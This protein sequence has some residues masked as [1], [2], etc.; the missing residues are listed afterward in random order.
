MRAVQAAKGAGSLVRGNSRLSSW[1]SST[2]IAAPALPFWWQARRSLG[3]SSGSNDGS[4]NTME[5][6]YGEMDESG[7]TFHMPSYTTE[8]GEKIKDVQL[9]YRTWG[10]LNEARDNVLVVCHALTGNAA[11][12]DW[13]GSFLGDG[14]PFDTSKYYVICSNLLGS[15]YGST[16][17]SSTNADNHTRWGPEF[18]RITVRD[19]VNLQKQMVRWGEGVKQVK[20]VI[21]GSLGG[22]QTLEWLFHDHPHCNNEELLAHTKDDQ[23]FVRSAMPMACGT[24][25]HTWQI[26][27]SE[28]Q[29]QCIYADPDFQEGWYYDTGKMPRSGI[30]LARMQA[31]VSYRSHA[32]YETKFGRRRMDM[33][34][35]EEIDDEFETGGPKTPTF[36]ENP[37]TVE[38]YLRY[39]GKKFYDR[40]DANSYVTLTQMM[41]TH[42]IG[43]GRG[44][45]ARAAASCKQPLHVIGIDS[46]VLYPILE[47]EDLA[48]VF[49]NANLSIVR[50]DDGHDGFLLAQDSVGPI[51]Q[52]FLEK[53]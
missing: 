25:H 44:G 47:Q 33:E 22:M 42:D 50:S 37:F 4:S 29:R 17:P 35:G 46:D 36:Y 23:P 18:P 2:S 5:D 9:R 12:N 8:S 34:N 24:H 16:G 48:A 26:A 31:M 51:I 38:S 19:A 53:I 1:M 52:E 15:C 27:V 40:F 3:S 30:G 49:P 14:L 45:V 7:K 43:R 13:W 21:G 6:E 32:A 10:E 11:L 28:A 20:C 39:Q 41:D